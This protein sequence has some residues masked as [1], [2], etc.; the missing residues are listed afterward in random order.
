MQKLMQMFMQN[1]NANSDVDA[2]TYLS[3]NVNTGVL[4]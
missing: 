1:I 4:Y 3:A 2:N